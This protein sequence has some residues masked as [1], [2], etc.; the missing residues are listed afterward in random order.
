MGADQ[1]IY[2]LTNRTVSDGVMSGVAG[3][4]APLAFGMV[5]SRHGLLK[6]A[7]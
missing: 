1:D 2:D 7:R 4:S 3:V 5:G 6:T